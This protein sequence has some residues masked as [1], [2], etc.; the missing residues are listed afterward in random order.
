MEASTDGMYD[1]ALDNIENYVFIMKYI[2]KLSPKLKEVIQLHYFLDYS[3][4]TIAQIIGVPVGTV[5]SRSSKALKKMRSWL[6][7]NA[8]EC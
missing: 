1:L 4:E 3:Y 2:N 7:G 6:G 8:D 5:K